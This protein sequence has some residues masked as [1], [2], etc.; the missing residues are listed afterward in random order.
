MSWFISHSLYIGFLCDVLVAFSFNHGQILWERTQESMSCECPTCLWGK[1]G[2]GTTGSH[3]YGSCTFISWWQYSCWAYQTQSSF[4]RTTCSYHKMEPSPFTKQFC[5]IIFCTP[6]CFECTNS[7]ALTE[8]CPVHKTTLTAHTLFQE[9]QQ[10][11]DKSEG[12]NTETD[13]GSSDDLSWFPVGLKW[14][15]A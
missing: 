6:K 15:V 2:W 11:D 4:M 8:A 3:L 7:T 12:C 14:G 9:I 10:M 13:D 5:H 1:E